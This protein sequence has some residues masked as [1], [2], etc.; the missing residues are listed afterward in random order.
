M[1]TP[2][3]FD[4]SA[5]ARLRDLGGN[6]FVAQMIGLFLELARRKLA[7][8]RAAETRK[9]FHALRMAVHPLRSS[10][11]NVGATSVMELSTRIDELARRQEVTTIPALL[12]ELETAF[13]RVEPR[14]ERERQSSQP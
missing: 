9:D 7:E 2:D 13:A 10:G 14:L 8:A 4:E 11:G 5:L 6:E 12:A 3:T 1:S